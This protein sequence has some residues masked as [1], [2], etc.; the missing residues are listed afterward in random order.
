[1]TFIKNAR[2]RVGQDI[3]FADLAVSLFWFSMETHMGINNVDL[4]IYELQTVDGSAVKKSI[5]QKLSNI[6]L[7]VLASILY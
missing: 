6:L 5:E 2:A 4:I 3:G 1:M 7:L